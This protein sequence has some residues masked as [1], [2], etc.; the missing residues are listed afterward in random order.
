MNGRITEFPSLTAY[1]AVARGAITLERYAS[2]SAEDLAP[3]TKTLSIAR[4][5]PIREEACAVLAIAREVC[6][7]AGD[8]YASRHVY[9]ARLAIQSVEQ[10]YP[11][12]LLEAA[13]SFDPWVTH[14]DIRP[15][16]Q[17]VSRFCADVL[18]WTHEQEREREIRVMQEF[19]ARLTVRVDPQTKLPGAAEW[20]G[21]ANKL[22]RALGYDVEVDDR[23]RTRHGQVT[24]DSDQLTFLFS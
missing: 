9:S 15:W 2:M 13:E 18:R 7:E 12:D 14:D 4:L 22:K 6:E 10:P 20:E 1:R 3:R 5:G 24:F 19:F 17:N 11:R 16:L 21:I 23:I 8:S